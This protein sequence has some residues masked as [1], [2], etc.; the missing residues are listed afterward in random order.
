MRARN[1]RSRLLLGV[2]AVLALSVGLTAC[3]SNVDP[4][5]VA[6]VNGQYL[7][8]STGGVDGSGAPLTGDA[9][10]GDGGSSDSSGGGGGGTSSGGD[11]AG[12]PGGDSGGESD[13]GGGGG[14]DA[15]GE[16]APAAGTNA[17]DCKGFDTSQPGVT[18]D[19][20]VVANASDISGP[21]PG[22]FE[23]ARKATQAFAMY[24]NASADI[25]GRKLEVLTLDSRSDGG[26]DQQAY[27]AACDK[28]FAAVGSMSAFDS[29]GAQTAQSCGLPDV[30]STAV[31][32][33]RSK[34]TTCFAAQSVSP[35][36]VP[37]SMPAYWKKAQ[38]DATQKVGMVYINVGAAK[39][40]AESFRAAWEKA[41]WKVVYFQGMDVSEFNY[42]PYVQGMKDRGVQMVNYTGPY[43][44][45]VKLQQSMQQGGLD[46]KVFLQDSTIYT[47]DY[48]EQ[49]GENGE[50]SYVYSTTAL[51]DDFSIAEMKLY[52]SWLSRID[53]SAEPD[54]YGVYAWSAARLFTEKA[55][56][57]G[58]GLNRRSLISA[59]SKTSGWT[60]NGLHAPQSIGSK[61]TAN[62]VKIFQ[63]NGGK[64]SQK[65][66]G[67][68]LC[69]PLT[70]TGIGG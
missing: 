57:L 13:T 19:K 68:Y 7:P 69:G 66:P 8:G 61:K 2:G 70:D 53:P 63:L 15:G 16:A 60:G 28:S 52:R 20:I 41:G 54:M 11:A 67:K 48:V 39:V 5:T 62:C 42:A 47:Q 3:G 58:G 64:W 30:R 23:S 1:R 18:D 10:T 34:C 12:G 45:T 32:P 46:P 21:V 27:T 51:F 49:A 29:G 31:T 43:Q 59:L 37:S 50:G 55:A 40:N 36:L 25:C 44:N 22:I 24:F 6:R 33:E 17:A 65:S 9:G 35:N 4:E 38:P 56:A 14:G 26:A